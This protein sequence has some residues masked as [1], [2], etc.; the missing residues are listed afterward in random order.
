M[1]F[2]LIPPSTFAPDSS[3]IYGID[4]TP[5][6]YTPSSIAIAHLIPAKAG[7]QKDPGFRVKPGMTNYIRIM[8]SC[9]LITIYQNK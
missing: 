8:S 2:L 9:I 3:G 1:V 7:I 5:V 6:L 4:A